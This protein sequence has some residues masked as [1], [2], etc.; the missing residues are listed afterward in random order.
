MIFNEM[1]ALRRTKAE[2]VDA[3][4]HTMRNQVEVLSEDT[5]VSDAIIDF[6]KAFRSL[7]SQP[8]SSEMNSGLENY[9]TSQFFP[10][11]FANLPGQAEY[12]LYR[13]A[14]PAALYLQ[15]HYIA[16]T[17]YG[18]EAEKMLL[19]QAKDGSEYHTVMPITIRV[20]ATLFKSWVF[21]I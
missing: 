10:K 8:I 1:V 17:P 20:F 19:D 3:Y 11:L 21:T 4:F 5:M 12:S 13:P 16:A 18:N 15:Y 7:D 6:G 14:N 9:Y 2:E